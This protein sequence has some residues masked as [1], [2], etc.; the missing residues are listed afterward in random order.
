MHSMRILG[1]HLQRVRLFVGSTQTETV[2]A[3]T[4]CFELRVASIARNLSNESCP[5]LLL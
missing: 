2:D 3:I 5:T 1:A 4:D